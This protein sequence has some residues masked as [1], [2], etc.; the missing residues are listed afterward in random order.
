MPR[1]VFSSSCVC[2]LISFIRSLLNAERAT[3]WK[4]GNMGTGCSSGRGAHFILCFSCL[5]RLRLARPMRLPCFLCRCSSPVSSHASFSLRLGFLPIL[6]SEQVLTAATSFHHCQSDVAIGP[7][8]VP[9]LPLLHSC[10]LLGLLLS[11]NPVWHLCGTECIWM[12]PWCTIISP[13]LLE[14]WLVNSSQHLMSASTIIQRKFGHQVHHHSQCDQT[15]VNVHLADL[16][17]FPPKANFCKF[18]RG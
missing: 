10:I 7:I 5:I 2:Y 12:T 6:S 8:T 16:N 17:P 11:H 9:P 15:Q 13:R 14:H 4:Q 3:G 18:E 1:I